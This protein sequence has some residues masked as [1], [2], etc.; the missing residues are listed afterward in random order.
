MDKGLDPVAAIEKSWYMTRGH[1]WRIFGMYLLSF[2][3]LLRA[4]LAHRPRPLRLALMSP[5]RS[6]RCITRSISRSKR[7]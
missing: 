1:G 2:L 5:P 6:H 7:C 4:A 3:V